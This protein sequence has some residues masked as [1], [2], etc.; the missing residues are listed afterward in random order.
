MGS[1]RRELGK[2][3]NYHLLLYFCYKEH[4]VI[5]NYLVILNK[6]HKTLVTS[7]NEVNG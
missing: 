1:N 6:L 5:K 4:F 3:K 7:V 2:N